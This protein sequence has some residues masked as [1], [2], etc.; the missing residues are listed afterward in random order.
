MDDIKV[1]SR[2]VRK[3]LE[4]FAHSHDSVDEDYHKDKQLTTMCAVASVFL[5]NILTKHGFSASVR[6]LVAYGVSHCFVDVNE[7]AIDLTATQMKNV[8]R[9]VVIKPLSMYLNWSPL[10]DFFC[11]NILKMKEFT[12]ND[13]PKCQSP[14][15]EILTKLEEI[16]Y[17]T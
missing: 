9:K 6:E 2:K 13:W 5:A 16:Y 1:I 8:K 4:I 14:R 3:T 10:N 12:G 7:M 17:D 11:N 15:Q